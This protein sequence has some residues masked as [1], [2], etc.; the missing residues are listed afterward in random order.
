MEDA[1]RNAAP[2][3]VDWPT[4]Q[5]EMDALRVREKAHTREGDAIAVDLIC[6]LRQGSDV[7][8]TYWTTRRGVE[9]TDNNYRLLDLTVYGRQQEW[10]DS[11]PDW[12]QAPEG[13]ST[14]G[15]PSAQWPRLKAGHSDD[16]T[17][18]L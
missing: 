10:E 6:Y 1:K 11:P 13:M 16:L 18:K 3:I 17:A 2:S 15:R 5:A 9:A 12:P 8:E 14:D 7:F 4:F